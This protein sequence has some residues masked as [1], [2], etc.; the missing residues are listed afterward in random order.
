MGKLV[1]LKLGDGSFEQGFPVTLQIGQ[2]GTRPETEIT[3]KLPP[4]PEIPKH[5]RSWQSTYR[6]LGLSS[7][8]E[9]LALQGTNVSLIDECDRAAQLLSDSLN[10]WLGAESFRPLRDKWLEKLMPAHEIRVLLQTEALELQQLPWHLW[11]LFER[12]PF[13][14]IALSAPAY[15]GVAKRT[16]ARA[17]VKMLAIL[18]NSTEINIQADRAMLEHL[19]DAEICFLVEPQCQELTEQ[20]WEQGW[21]ILFFAGYS[22]GQGNGERG[23]IYINQADS[24]TTDQ[25]YDAVK[26]AVAGGLQL[27]I[28]NS[29]EGWGLARELAHLKIPQIII[30]REPVPNWVAQEFLKYFL[31]AFAQGKSFYLA[32]REAR[33]RLQELEDKFPYA[34]WLPVICHNPAAVP[35]T[36]QELYNYTDSEL[37]SRIVAPSEKV[38]TLVFTDLVNSTAVKN[39]LEG[40][41]ITER[42]RLYRDTI[43]N[44]HRQRVKAS[45]PDYH[46]RVVETI[47]DAFFLV[48]SEP[49]MAVQWAVAIQISHAN[50]PIPTPLGPLQVRIGMHMG[51]PLVDS[52]RFIGQEVDYAARVSALASG[53]QILLS[54]ATEVFIRN[55]NIASLTLYPQGL[56]NLKGIGEVPIFELLWTEEQLQIHKTD[57]DRATRRKA[58]R[59]RYLLMGT[60]ILVTTLVI[61]LRWLGVLESLELSTFDRLLRLRPDEEPDPRLL[62]VTITEADIQN[63]NQEQ[64]RGSLSDRALNQLLEKLELYQPRAIGLDIYR[65][66]SVS[67]EYQDLAARLQQNDRLIAI[68]KGKDPDTDTPEVLPPPEV[69]G[70]RLGFSD[71]VEDEDGVLRRHLLFMTQ[72]PV[73]RCTASYAFNLQLAFR[74]L[75]DMGI[76]PQFTPEGNLQL[77]STVFQRLKARTGGYQPEDA[78]GNQVL[79]NYRSLSSPEKIA[80]QVELTEVLSNQFNPDAVKDRVILIGVTALSAGDYWSTPYRAGLSDKI[81]GVFIQA[82]MVSQ[83]LSAVLDRRPLLWVWPQWGEAFWIWVWSL[84]GSIIAWRFRRLAY[85][86]LAVGA[87]LGMLSGLCFVLLTH[88]GRWVPLVPSVLALVATGG[89][90]AYTSAEFRKSK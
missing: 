45:L 33:K 77:G 79:L 8:I 1:V 60:S 64:R 27:A 14:E 54:E 67:P 90:V 28:F 74:Y 18:G 69:D 52:D 66:F 57:L 42:N 3:G 7:S 62:V 71:F 41:S 21:D 11:D 82:H 73:S 83:I 76:S 43:L 80:S 32:V 36:W 89:T 48:F 65:D 10:V 78:G 23:R 9:P 30:M 59:S 55:A 68:C 25:L 46:G 20:L 51:C 70:K 31:A 5:Y 81:P 86:G 17:K 6:C 12:Y 47:G 63:Q 37:P 53:R 16:R 38:L 29:C 44:P 88:W 61:G 50:D 2:D 84:A 58:K 15:Q 75:H 39:H 56:R 85:L 72:D 13:S 87:A 35:P 40:T 4:V 26:K 34:S 24:L 19:P 22:S 49:V